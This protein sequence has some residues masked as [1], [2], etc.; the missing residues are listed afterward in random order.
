MLSG[1][2]G[3]LNKLIRCSIERFGQTA[4]L[5]LYLRIESIVQKIIFILCVFTVNIKLNI[6]LTN[7]LH[8][9][10]FSGVVKGVVCDLSN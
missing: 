2:S 3:T 5:N 6:K 8:Q 1:T 7:I 10:S 4:Q 9:V